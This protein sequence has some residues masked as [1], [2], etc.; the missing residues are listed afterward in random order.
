GT[1]AAA[2]SDLN[3]VYA[4]TER[5]GVYRSGDGGRT[6]ARAGL[7]EA[8]PVAALRVHPASPETVYAAVIA[9]GPT[10][11]GRG[12]T[13]TD[14]GGRTWKPGLRLHEPSP[15]CDLAL[16]PARPPVVVVAICDGPASGLQRSADGG[17]SWTRLSNGLPRGPFARVAV[18]PSPA[19]SGR[20]YAS[21]EAEDGGL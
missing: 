5:D 3:V 15:V 17:E 18:A 9:A 12:L 6:W 4:G 8:R 21:L 7:A 1:L 11:R 13:R 10:G 20:V 14:D 16:T 19:R 2:A